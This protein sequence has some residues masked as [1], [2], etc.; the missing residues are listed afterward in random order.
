MLKPLPR[1]CPL[2]APDLVSMWTWTTEFLSSD[3]IGSELSSHDSL[4]KVK[5]GPEN[6]VSHLPVTVNKKMSAN[7]SA[8]SLTKKLILLRPSSESG[9]LL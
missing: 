8:A 5:T 2:E 4:R 9:S 7:K 6:T 1:N 3:T